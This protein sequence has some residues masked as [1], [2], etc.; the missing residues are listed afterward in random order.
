MWLL[1]ALTIKVTA[2]KIL[3]SSFASTAAAP[4]FGYETPWPISDSIGQ[5]Y[6]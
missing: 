6:L 4:C 5:A 2:L 1:M 3:A